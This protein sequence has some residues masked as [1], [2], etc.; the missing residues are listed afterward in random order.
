MPCRDQGFEFELADE[1]ALTSEFSDAQFNTHCD[2]VV[3]KYSRL[4][5]GHRHFPVME[6]DALPSFGDSIEKLPLET[7]E[8]ATK[9]ALAEAEKGNK[10]DFR[11]AVERLKAQAVSTS[12]NVK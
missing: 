12:T 10:V 9:Y 7:I 4:P 5:V 3:T 8:A 6:G 2:R 11:K 1:L